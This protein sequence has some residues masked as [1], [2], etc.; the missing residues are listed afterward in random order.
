MTYLHVYKNRNRSNLK[1][2]CLEN[3]FQLI[4]G[5]SFPFFASY[6]SIEGNEMDSKGEGI[7]TI[8]VQ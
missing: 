2:L 3:Y 5:L 7:V 6:K 4:Y 1:H 8:K